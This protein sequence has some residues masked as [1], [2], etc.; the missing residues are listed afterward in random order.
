M[1]NRVDKQTIHRIAQENGLK[2]LI[3]FGSTVDKNSIQHQESDI[4]IAFFGK[5]KM[6][7]SELINLQYL[8]ARHFDVQEDKIDLT[9]L[10]R[11]N[12]LISRRVADSGQ[13]LFD[14]DGHQYNNF[15]L[16]AIK[17]FID[18]QNLYELE[19]EILKE[20]I[21]KKYDR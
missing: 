10:S 13:V 7:Y 11:A 20:K 1:K 14:N 9:D 2:L 12:S 21:A 4:D 6:D 16:S 17:K 8:L 5:N 3:Q 19:K 18:E 15:Y